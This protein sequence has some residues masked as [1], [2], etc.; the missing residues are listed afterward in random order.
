MRDVFEK[1]VNVNGTKKGPDLSSVTVVRLCTVR[2]FTKLSYLWS[3]F[4]EVTPQIYLATLLINN[5]FK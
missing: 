5:C 3:A 1:Q 4:P 2:H